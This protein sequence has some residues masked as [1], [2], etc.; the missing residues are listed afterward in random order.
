MTIQEEK[1][2]QILNLLDALPEDRLD[3]VA[4]FVEFL[5]AK[6]IAQ[7]TDYVPVRLD[8]LWCGV[9]IDDEDIAAVRKELWANLS[10]RSD[11][12]K[13]NKVISLGV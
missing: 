10:S 5:Y 4:N 2:Q 3:E 13:Q 6:H 9:V 7:P 11:E 8:G 1:R 12:V